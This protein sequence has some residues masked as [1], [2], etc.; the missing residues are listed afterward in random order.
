MAVVVVSG[1]V[2]SGEHVV[3]KGGIL[4]I[5]R[6]SECD[7]VL[8]DK[9]VSARHARIF[10]RDKTW[11]ITDLGAANGIYL[12]KHRIGQQ[13]IKPGDEFLIAQY[14]LTFAES[15]ESLAEKAEASMDE[16]RQML[17]GRL[18]AEL[19]LRRLTIDQML[20][21]AFRQRATDLLDRLVREREKDIPAQY[22]REVLKKAVLDAALGLGP[23]EDLLADEAVTEIMVNGPQ[24]IFVETRGRLK[25]STKSFLGKAEILTAIERIVGP[26]GRSIN[27]STPTVDARLPDGSRVHAI[28]PPLALDGPTITIR[29][30]PKKG[31]T[32]EDL[33][34]FETLSQPMSE[35]LRLAVI[36]AKNTVFQGGLARGRPLR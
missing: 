8:A 27:E 34:A 9:N 15:A 18:I 3:I 14:R 21:R 31:I 23:L 36:S 35:F 24:R 29:K 4:T 26:I 25:R 13:A 16:I 30:F 32:I 12:G 33:V 6:S 1:G 28:I 17:H 5:G 19:N 7:L 20:D 11:Y 22:D 2:Y 10:L